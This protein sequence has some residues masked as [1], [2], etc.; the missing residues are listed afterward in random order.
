MPAF[1]AWG[2]FPF[3][4]S[5]IRSGAVTPLAT[6]YF[7]TQSYLGA[8]AST[9]SVC[10]I[11]SRA[12]NATLF[13]STGTL[14]Y[15]PNNQLLNS[16]TLST[17][18]VTTTPV[19]Y[20]LSIY[21]T[22]SVVLSGTKVATLSGTGASNQVYLAFTPTAGTLTLTVAG[23]VTSAVLAQVTYETA[24]RSG[25]Q[26]ITTST[27][28]YGPRFDYTG[29]SADGWL[30]EG[31]ATNMLAYSQVFT[32]NWS[33]VGGTPTLS[34]T[35]PDGSSK[36][37]LFTENT[38][39]SAHSFYGLVGTVS[40]I[41]YVLSIYVQAGTQRYIS[42]RGDATTLGNP[43]ITFDTT[44]LSI[45]SNAAVTSSGFTSIGGGVYRI[46]LS[47]TTTAG[48]GR[49]AVV[50]GSNTATAPGTA[51]TTGISYLGTGLTWY[52]WGIQWVAGATPDSY[53]PTTTVAVTRAA[54][55]P[56]SASPLTALLAAYPSV[57]EL[58]DEA[59]GVITRAQYAA[60][61]FTYPVGK[62]YRSMAV[63][64]TIPSRWLT[65][66]ALYN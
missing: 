5:M 37:N 48:G 46:W 64:P 38:S 16:A 7:L 36:W 66:G 21:G 26:V 19:N 12:G 24:P 57:W 13:D 20:I 17:Q 51:V 30:N 52:A 14:T 1:A 47:F 50:A 23:S 6:Q 9:F 44:A 28:Y 53:I 49:N 39:T 65:V 33:T 35:S 22:G 27:A 3:T 11:D 58:Q 2:M 40:A 32:S 10:N 15:A 56:T 55:V 34:T 45:N 54:D 63:N 29:G 8:C 42:V 18:S 25:D 4:S 61:T 62:W 43:W 59:T 41:P 60:G 31:A